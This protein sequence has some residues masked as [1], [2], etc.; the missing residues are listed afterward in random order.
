MTAPLVWQVIWVDANEHGLGACG[1]H[2]ATADEATACAFEPDGLPV[3]CA[4]LIRQVRDPDYVT[5]GQ[6]IAAARLPQ[7]LE[8]ALE[9]G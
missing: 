6:R 8:L 1:H 7:Q 9:A 3:M 4:G 5:V 2:H